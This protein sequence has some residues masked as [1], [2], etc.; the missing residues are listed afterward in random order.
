MAATRENID[1]PS[2]EF[3][4]KFFSIEVKARQKENEQAI[5]IRQFGETGHRCNVM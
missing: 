5:A 2:I 4:R 3:I 1:I